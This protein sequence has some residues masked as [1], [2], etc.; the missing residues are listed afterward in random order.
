MEDKK[1]PQKNALL[2]YAG[3]ATQLV[4]GIALGVLLGMW[5]DKKIGFTLLTWLLPLLI[6]IGMLV[7]L[8]KDTSTKK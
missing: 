7:K 5:V 3:I 1:P 2:Q 8:V 6:M 4:V